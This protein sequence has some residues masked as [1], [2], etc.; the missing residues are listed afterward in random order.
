MRALQPRHFPPWIRY[1]KTGINSNADNVFP[2][3]GQAE[4]RVVNDCLI[5]TL[6]PTT[7]KK[8]PRTKSENHDFYKIC[9][10]QDIHFLLAPF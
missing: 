7:L 8:E 3:L 6:K 5:G 10:I 1:D 4:R 9:S 2:Q